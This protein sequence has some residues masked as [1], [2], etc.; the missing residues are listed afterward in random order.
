[1]FKDYSK[2]IG[3]LVGGLLYVNSVKG[4]PAP[5]NFNHKAQ[6]YTNAD[7]GTGDSCSS[8]TCNAY[9]QCEI[10]LSDP[11]TICRPAKGSCDAAEYC[12][13][14]HASCPHDD[15]YDSDYSCRASSGIFFFGLHSALI[16]FV[17]LHR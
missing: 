14:E 17:L 5:A 6:C 15:Y 13:G 10:V 16:V 7:C 11:H 1:M 9:G 2:V 8:Y 3:A 4:D 12:T